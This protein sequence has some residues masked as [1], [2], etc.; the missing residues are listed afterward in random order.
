[1]FPAHHAE[2]AGADYAGSFG[3]ELNAYALER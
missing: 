3:G 1:L 2:R